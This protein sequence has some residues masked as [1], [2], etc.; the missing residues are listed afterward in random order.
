MTSN[1]DTNLG[2]WFEL[3]SWNGCQELVKTRNVVH[4][5]CPSNEAFEVGFVD[6][7]NGVLSELDP[8]QNPSVSEKRTIS[9]LEQSY[10]V[11]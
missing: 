3:C 1:H 6:T 5:F 2:N 11:R 4:P 7:S 8:Y 9:A 10:F